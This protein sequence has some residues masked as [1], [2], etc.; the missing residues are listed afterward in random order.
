MAVGRLQQGQQERRRI[1]EARPD[2]RQRGQQERRRIVGA[3]PDGRNPIDKKRAV[4]D[5]P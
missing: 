2:G 3:R 4:N 5:R 1:V